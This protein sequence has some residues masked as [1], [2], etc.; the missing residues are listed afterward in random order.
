MF[1]CVDHVMSVIRNC[2]VVSY[3]YMCI[4]GMSLQSTK[5]PDVMQHAARR[6]ALQS[7][8]CSQSAANRFNHAATRNRWLGAKSCCETNTHPHQVPD[9]SQ[10]TT[11]NTCYLAGC[12][13]G[14]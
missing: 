12:R 11:P 10:Q 3:D 6:P 8:S 13:F 2:T 14:G 4:L 1:G 5:E 9:I 7:Y